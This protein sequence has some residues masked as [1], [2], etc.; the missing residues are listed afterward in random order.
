[1]IKATIKQSEPIHNR[2][3]KI[4]DFTPE[5]KLPDDL[6]AKIIDAAENK[7][8]KDFDKQFDKSE[9]VSNSASNGATPQGSESTESNMT[10]YTKVESVDV[11]DITDDHN[12]ADDFNIDI[13]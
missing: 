4:F 5:R 10:T 3:F 7:Y 6:V 1:L 13:I 8:M 11:P 12:P 9:S 2:R